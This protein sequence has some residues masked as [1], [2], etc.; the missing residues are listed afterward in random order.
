MLFLNRRLVAGVLEEHFRRLDAGLLSQTVRRVVQLPRRDQ[1][2]FHA[3]L[4]F[5]RLGLKRNDLVHDRHIVVTA[6]RA[7]TDLDPHV[8]AFSP[9]RGVDLYPL[10]PKPGYA[11]LG[12]VLTKQGMDTEEHVLDAGFSKGPGNH[13]DATCGP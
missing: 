11:G 7:Q 8:S 13:P 5:D 9:L 12:G 4:R 2:A 6:T 1:R 10:A 3:A